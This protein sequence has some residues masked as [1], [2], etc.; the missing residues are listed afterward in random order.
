M[1]KLNQYFRDGAGLGLATIAVTLFASAPSYAQDDAKAVLEPVVVAQASP[2]SAVSS[3]AASPDA[4]P[5]HQRGVR[6]AAAQGPESLRRYVY[7]TR[8]IY[9]FNYNDFAPRE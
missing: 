2:N 9:G 6:A 5:A 3:G 7:R 8:M 1:N 4:F